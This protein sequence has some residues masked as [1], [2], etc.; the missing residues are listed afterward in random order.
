M[1]SALGFVLSVAREYRGLGLSFEDL[2]GEGNVGL[3]DAARRFGAT[4]GTKFTTYAIFWVR[5]AILGAL[6]TKARV[7]RSPA[8]S[9]NKIREVRDVENELRKTLGSRPTREELSDRLSITLEQLDRAL[10]AET[11]A[12]NL[13]DRA[14]RDG[15]RTLEDLL[16]DPNQMTPEDRLIRREMKT[17]LDE[18]VSRLTETQ[19]VILERR[20]GL[21]GDPVETLDTVGRRLGL[22]RERVRQIEVEAKRRVRRHLAKRSLPLRRAL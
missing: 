19:Q 6:S 11:R 7:I 8:Y 5:R 1:H 10:S 3:M 22:S 9:M 20:F 17:V 14:G 15:S 16:Q 13:S 12:I 18:A 4:R 21:G 2:V